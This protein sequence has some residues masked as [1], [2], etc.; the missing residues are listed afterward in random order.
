MRDAQPQRTRPASLV[1]LVLR[2]L[3]DTAIPVVRL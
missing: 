1:L 2:L 3:P